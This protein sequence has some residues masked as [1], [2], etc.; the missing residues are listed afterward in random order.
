[1]LKTLESTKGC[2]RGI[3]KVPTIGSVQTC[4]DFCFTNWNFINQFIQLINRIRVTVLNTS[5]TILLWTYDIDR[6]DS[7]CKMGSPTGSGTVAFTWTYDLET[8]N[9]CIVLLRVTVHCSLLTSSEKRQDFF[10]TRNISYHLDF[11]PELWTAISDRTHMD[12]AQEDVH[13]AHQCDWNYTK[14]PYCIEWF[15]L[16]EDFRVCKSKFCH[17]IRQNVLSWA[18]FP[19]SIPLQWIFAL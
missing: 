10:K 13:S 3:D 17:I 11:P 8:P 19:P 6:S 1:M 2:K 12:I 9:A 7:S 15:F 14:L 5:N 16:D 4:I 18:E